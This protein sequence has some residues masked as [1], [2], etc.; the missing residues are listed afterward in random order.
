VLF[1]DPE[2]ERACSA[3]IDAARKGLKVGEERTV[4]CSYRESEI[5]GGEAVR[6]F[7][8][9]VDVPSATLDPAERHT[10]AI[11]ISR[12]I[13]LLCPPLPLDAA[14]FA[15]A[16]KDGLLPQAATYEDHVYSTNLLAHLRGFDTEM[17]SGV[18]SLVSCSFQDL[19][20]QAIRAPHDAT[21]TLVS[22]AGEDRYSVWNLETD[23]A[24]AKQYDKG[25]ELK[26]S[27][28]TVHLVVRPRADLEYTVVLK[29]L[30]KIEAPL[31]QLRAGSV[32]STLDKSS[33]PMQLEI[34]RAY[35][36]KGRFL[37]GS[38]KDHVQL[39]AAD[40]VPYIK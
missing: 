17:V 24:D 11:T 30:P 32:I 18:P 38:E 36:A 22:R 39:L 12:T 23:K 7:I 34:H 31:G 5:V 6:K 4:S 35:T 1:L 13:E 3:A 8:A 15:R 14:A 26:E 16:K 27:G 10:P 40:G 28:N 2:F 37:R 21:L 19:T 29:N 25:R 33:Q 20:R 9:L